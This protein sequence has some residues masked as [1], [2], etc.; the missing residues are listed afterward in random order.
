M[1]VEDDSEHFS[2]ASNNNPIQTSMP[3]FGVSKEICE[4]DYNQLKVPVF[5]CQ[6]VNGNT[7]VHRDQMGFTL[8]DLNK[9]AYK[10]EPLIIAE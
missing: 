8:V 4:H 5:Q 1:I 6:W 7:G 2:S 3:Y 9:V 10:E